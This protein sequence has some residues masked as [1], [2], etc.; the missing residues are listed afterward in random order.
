[1]Q[2]SWHPCYLSQSFRSCNRLHQMTLLVSF[3][4]SS[5][6]VFEL[7]EYLEFPSIAF[8]NQPPSQR[9]AAYV[10]VITVLKTYER[11]DKKYI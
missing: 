10:D 6:Q 3:H 4:S 7:C 2:E 1:M 8:H 5:R 9:H 11:S